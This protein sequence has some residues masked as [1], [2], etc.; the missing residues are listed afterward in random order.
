MQD[1]TFA[2]QPDPLARPVFPET[3]LASLVLSADSSPRALWASSSVYQRTDT[4]TTQ[5]NQFFATKTRQRII[6]RWKAI[7]PIY[8]S[9]RWGFS[10]KKPWDTQTTSAIATIQANLELPDGTQTL[11]FN[12]TNNGGTLIPITF[13]GR[14]TARLVSG[15]ML[16]GDLIYASDHGRDYWEFVDTDLSQPHQQPWVRTAWSKASA[17]D[18]LWYVLPN[19]NGGVAPQQ[20]AVAVGTSFAQMQTL[21]ST[22]GISSYNG[23]NNWGFGDSDGCPGPAGFIGI[24]WDSNQEAVIV[25]GTSIPFGETQESRAIGFSASEFGTGT[26]WSAITWDCGQPLGWPGWASTTNNFAFPCF[27]LAIGASA[28]LNTWNE[29]GAAGTWDVGVSTYAD[30]I[31]QRWIFSLLGRYFTVFIAQDVHN[32]NDTVAN[33]RQACYSFTSDIL[34]VNPRI[35]IFGARVPNGGVDFTGTNQAYAA[36]LADRW[37]VQEEMV[38]NG[39][40]AGIL[41]LRLNGQNPFPNEGTIWTG[42]LGSGSTTTQ[43]ELGSP[44]LQTGQFTRAWV[45]IGAD[46]RII[47]TCR[48][49]F[50]QISTALSGAPAAGTAVTIE[51][52]WAGGAAGTDMVHTTAYG[53]K[54]MGELFHSEIVKYIPTF[55]FSPKPR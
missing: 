12:S 50:F 14:T 54:R 53:A 34:R 46:R 47:S 10:V 27:N 39:W 44:L 25:M 2:W 28:L 9:R 38:A 30:Y 51:G 35:K 42:V 31:Y 45:T 21:I 15:Q 40:W 37:A 20:S 36:G 48:R 18:N 17:S 4:S 7:A 5:T 11:N 19:T 16:V 32:D 33:Y 55:K 52:N 49:S 22:P 26:D 24:P 8:I 1:V 23:A 13:Q 29:S 43:M 41:D 3:D 6:G